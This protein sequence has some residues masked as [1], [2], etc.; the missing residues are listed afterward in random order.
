MKKIASGIVFVLLSILCLSAH[1]QENVA[2]GFNGPENLAFDGKG[3]LY[4]SDTDHLYVL[5]PAGNKKELYTR[6]PKADATSLGGVSLGPGGRIYFSTGKAI[7]I[8]NPADGAIS[9]LARGFK[10]ANGNCFNDAGDLF[11]ADSGARKL[12]VIPHGTTEKRVI[13]SGMGSVAQLGVNGLIWSRAGNTLYY[14][15]NFPA[16]VGAIVFGPDFT[17]VGHS[18][19]AR[20]PTGLD[21]L[22]L[23]SAGNLYVCLWM[24]GKLFKVTRDGER[25]LLLSNLDGP[26]AVE[27]A[28]GTGDLYILIKGKTMKFGGTDIIKLKT[29]ASGYKLPFLP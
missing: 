20:F 28:P 3:S 10:F 13:K 23:D 9:V 7:K 5:D 21:D 29:S 8:Y 14:T 15:Q 25:E 12:Y 24:K 16:R 26:S 18:T 22:T 19:V 17:I 11:I 27:F 4:V 2:T 1:A 6:E